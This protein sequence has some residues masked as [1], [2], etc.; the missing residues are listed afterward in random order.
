M[1]LD[2]E[3]PPDIRVENEIETLVSAGYEVH[4]ACY[5]Q[6]RRSSN[7]EHL[8]AQI[9]RKAISTF[10]Y[11]S[12]VA[13]LKFPFYFNFWRSFLKEL[14]SKLDFDAIHIHDLPLAKV[15]YEFSREHNIPYVLDLHENWPALLEI[16][17]HVNTPFGKLLSSTKQWRAYERKY[18]QHADH[19]ITVVE[20]MKD[21][22]RLLGVSG[23]SIYILNNTFNLNNK[24][25]FSSKTEEKQIVLYYAGGLNKHRGLQTVIKGMKPIV[26]KNKN[27]VLWIVGSGKYA[28]SLKQ[29]VIEENVA[30]YVKF[31]GQKP[32]TEAMHLLSKSDI[33]LIPHIKT[34][35]SDN[36]SPNKLFQYMYFKKPI[37]VSNCNSVVRIIEE[38]SS[39]SVYEFNNPASF[40][41]EVTEMIESG[42]IEQM[43]ENGKKSVLDK[44]NWDMSAK[45]LLSLYSNIRKD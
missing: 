20:E 10:L 38:T 34:E 17:E 6:E 29:I 45:S 27:V 24:Y 36:S 13:C 3:F 35:Q 18:A 4:V 32:Y 12:S 30:E 21:R 40:A 1:V 26:E 16:S 2:H 43:G 39:G 31:F 23:A 19:I 37:I 11:K 9:H 28:N 25:D 14:F 42:N 5:T 22:I 41:F 44:Y 7:D 33:A 8:G 15:G